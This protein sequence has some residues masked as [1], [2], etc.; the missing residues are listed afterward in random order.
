MEYFHIVNILSKWPLAFCKPLL[1]NCSVNLGGNKGHGMELDAFVE[2]DIVEPLKT[3]A[4]GYF[5]K[6]LFLTLN[7]IW[8]RVESTW[9]FFLHC[10]KMFSFHT[11]CINMMIHKL[12]EFKERR[13]AAIPNF[14]SAS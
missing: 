13:D 5:P 11:K 8:W 6:F 12:H 3:Y 14:F 4:S 1:Q 9:R 7:G 10:A 2:S